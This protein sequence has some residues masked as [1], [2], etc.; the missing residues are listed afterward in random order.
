MQPCRR[1]PVGVCIPLAMYVVAHWVVKAASKSSLPTNWVG[2]PP[3]ALSSL[4]VC[5]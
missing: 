1:V 4:V 5:L 2:V 3:V